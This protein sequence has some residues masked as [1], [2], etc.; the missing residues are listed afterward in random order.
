[1]PG[2]KGMYSWGFQ[3]FEGGMDRIFCARQRACVSSVSF[4]ASVV[5]PMKEMSF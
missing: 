3:H 1:M 5:L 2:V 4:E